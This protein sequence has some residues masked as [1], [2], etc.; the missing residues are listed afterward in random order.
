MSKFFS[1]EFKAFLSIKAI[2]RGLK[3]NIQID[4][5]I[6]K[7]FFRTA[8]LRN[9][10]KRRL[11]AALRDP[12]SVQIINKI[13]E[14]LLNHT[15]DIIPVPGDDASFPYCA[16]RARS[17]LGVNEQGEQRLDGNEVLFPGTGI[18]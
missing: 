9:K 1:K 4:F 13:Q 3:E 15:A 7:R 2:P 11:R 14:K 6:L 12:K 17:L 16:A 18:I 10:I 5:A 8:V